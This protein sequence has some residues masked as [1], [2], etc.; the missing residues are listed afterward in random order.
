MA[1]HATDLFSQLLHPSFFVSCADMARDVHDNPR[2]EDVATFPSANPLIHS[3]ILP[4]SNWFAQKWREEY[5]AIREA[6]M[7]LPL[8]LILLSSSVR[9]RISILLFVRIS[10]FPK[11]CVGGVGVVVCV[12]VCV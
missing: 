1:V 10:M 7:S 9:A 2:V 3:P 8:G 11:V 6:K 5:M 4:I 12:C